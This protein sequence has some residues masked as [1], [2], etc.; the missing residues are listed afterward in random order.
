MNNTLKQ[1]YKDTTRFYQQ[2]QNNTWMVLSKTTAWDDEEAPPTSDRRQPQKTVQLAGTPTN[3]DTVKLI[4]AS[5][6]LTGS[7][8]EISH[9]N[10]ADDTLADIASDL[11]TKINGNS[12]L[13]DAGIT[14]VYDVA[15]FPNNLI[16][17]WDADDLVVDITSEL[18][19]PGTVTEKLLFSDVHNPVIAVKASVY[20]I[21]E[22]PDDGTFTFIDSQQNERKFS[23]FPTPAD[24]LLG[25]TAVQSALKN[26]CRKILLTGQCLGSDFNAVA[27]TFRQVSFVTDLT[28]N[29]GQNGTVLNR[30]QIASWGDTEQ[31]ENRMSES[32]TST[33]RFKYS[34]IRQF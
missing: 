16:I 18:T 1:R 23:A 34:Y 20:L 11:A 14:A 26:R 8:I 2:N 22:D 28:P 27:S 31:Y 25:L 4:I 33:S 17:S 13:S 12:A 10:D 9:T 6:E 3:G 32:M 29:V 5:T 15:N 7:P 21:Y 30:T 24:A 19:G